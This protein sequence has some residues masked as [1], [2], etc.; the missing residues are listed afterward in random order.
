MIAIN[1][2]ACSKEFLCAF[3]AAQSDK[4]IRRESWP[5]GQFLRKHTIG[6]IAVFRDG[7]LSSPAWRG[8]LGS[9]QDATDWRVLD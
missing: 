5:E 3:D 7:E 8:P 6:T 9:E 1:R 2:E 4:A